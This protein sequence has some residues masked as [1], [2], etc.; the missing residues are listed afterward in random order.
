MMPTS[1]I[2]LA[3]VGNAGQGYINAQCSVEWYEILANPEQRKVE[4]IFRNVP[5]KDFR[6]EK[7]VNLCRFDVPEGKICCY[8]RHVQTKPNINE[9]KW[10]RLDEG[11][12]TELAGDFAGCHFAQ[13]FLNDYIRLGYDCTIRSG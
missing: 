6:R 12:F 9:R 13:L 5:M 7:R 11:Q 2:E 8:H 4:V 1:T 10:F 3:C